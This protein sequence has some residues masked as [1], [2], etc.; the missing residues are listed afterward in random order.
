MNQ[1]SVW[2]FSYGAQ[3]CHCFLCIPADGKTDLMLLELKLF[4]QYIF[5]NGPVLQQ[6]SSHQSA[7]GYSEQSDYK[8]ERLLRSKVLHTLTD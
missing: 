3:V 5:W 1:D 8:L 4:N 7:C 6:L 2:E